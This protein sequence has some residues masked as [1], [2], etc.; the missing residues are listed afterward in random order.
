M[1]AERAELYEESTHLQHSVE[2]M[3]RE[4]R[5]IEQELDWLEQKTLEARSCLQ[6]NEAIGGKVRYRQK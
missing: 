3:R 2:D 6:K 1:Q 4:K 5:R